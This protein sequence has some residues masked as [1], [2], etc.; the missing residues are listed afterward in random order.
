MCIRDRAHIVE[1]LLTAIASGFPSFELSLAKLGA[2][3]SLEH[4]KVVWIGIEDGKR[5]VIRIAE[6][7]DAE[8]QN[9]GFAAKA[10]TFSPHSTIGR[11]RSDGHQRELIK[12]IHALNDNVEFSGL[13]QSVTHQRVSSLELYQSVLTPQGPIHLLIHQVTLSGHA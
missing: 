9:R 7:L 11:I 4:P 6:K 2:F 12:K 5:E 10:R 13:D 1:Q 3:P 8:L